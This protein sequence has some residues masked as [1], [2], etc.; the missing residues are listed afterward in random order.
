MHLDMNLDGRWAAQ[1]GRL[2]GG[3][4]GTG[5]ERGALPGNF[6]GDDGFTSASARGRLRSA[7]DGARVGGRHAG[8]ERAHGGEDR[9]VVREQKR[10]GDGVRDP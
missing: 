7:G 1:G 4:E 5:P 3:L 9:S 6:G 8:E 10:G 2:T